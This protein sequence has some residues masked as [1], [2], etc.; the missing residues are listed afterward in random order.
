[1][2]SS[3][4]CSPPCR[5]TSG[6]T[7]PRPANGHRRRSSAIW[8]TAKLRLVFACARRWPRMG[9]RYNRSTRTSGRPPTAAGRPPLRWMRLLR[10]ANGTCGSSAPS[11]RP[12][13]T[14][15]R[16]IPSAARSPS[17]P[18]WR[19]WP[20]TISITLPSCGKLQT[21]TRPHKRRTLWARPRRSGWSKISSLRK[22]EAPWRRALY[23]PDL[24]GCGFLPVAA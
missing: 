16:S 5:R 14:G 3:P 13:Q 12:R 20:A 24:R 6:Q 21:Q 10:F 7:R 4:H 9:R 23:L 15:L 19:P 22:R 2:V 1:M 17:R 18:S 11:C 8:Q